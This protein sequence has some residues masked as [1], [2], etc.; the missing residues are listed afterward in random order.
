MIYSKDEALKELKK[1]KSKLYRQIVCKNNYMVLMKETGEKAPFHDLFYDPRRYYVSHALFLRQI[2][3]GLYQP[4][5]DHLLQRRAHYVYRYVQP[6]GL[7]QYGLL[8]CADRHY[9][10]CRLSSGAD[11]PGRSA[12]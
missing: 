5:E 1:I 3:P 7:P 6:S 8:S 12:G 10:R 11:A 9:G 4:G 2:K